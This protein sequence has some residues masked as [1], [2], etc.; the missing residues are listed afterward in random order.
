[1]WRSDSFCTARGL[2]IP[3]QNVDLTLDKKSSFQCRLR[4]F[5]AERA[6]GNE[7]VEGVQDLKDMH[8]Y[9]YWNGVREETDTWK[10]NAGPTFG[11]C[12]AETGLKEK[13]DWIM[14]V[15]REENNNVWHKLME[16][17]QVG[18]TLDILKIASDPVTGIPYLTPE[19]ANNMTIVWEDDRSEYLDDVWR[20]VNGKT[21][22]RKSAMQPGCY[23]NV[24]LPLPG[25]SSPFWL[26]LMEHLYHPVCES[27]FLIN[28]FLRR[29]Y[30]HFSIT[31]RFKITGK[32]VVTIIDRQQTRKIYNLKGMTENIR[33]K[34]PDH[35][36]NLV[37]FSTL[38]LREQIILVQS[39]DVLIG[40]H[41][42]GMTHVLFLPEESAVVEILPPTF[43]MLGFRQIGEMRGLHYFTEHSV[44]VGDWER[45]TLGQSE[46]G[47]DP[48]NED[49]WQVKEW[50]YIRE[51]DFEALVDA[52]LR[53]QYNR[54]LPYGEDGKRW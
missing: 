30:T 8:S 52:A 45:E 31:P 36:I 35:T 9:F 6:A 46:L 20:I 26:L 23:G 37:D 47:E 32:P 24:V 2:H 42:A 3:P 10:I 21:P 43:S 12:S 49:G 29:L 27:R 22:I 5:T 53:S 54:A 25:S 38:S 50:V 34:Y 39:T 41:G 44:W 48:K 11:D 13:K 33:K 51:R 40:H 15:K 19:E 4:N 14:L 7:D 1:M 18:I 16:I 17:W 28:A